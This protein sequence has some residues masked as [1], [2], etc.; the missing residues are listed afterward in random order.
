MNKLI[1]DNF[2]GFFEEN[3][4]L[5]KMR[6]SRETDI[7][8]AFI[9]NE[10]NSGKNL[11]FL[12]KKLVAFYD[13]RLPKE[14][15]TELLNLIEKNKNEIKNSEDILS[16]YKKYYNEFKKITGRNETS[17]TSKL[18][19][20]YNKNI[21]LYDSR[22]MKF[23]TDIGLPEEN[24]AIKKYES[25]FNTYKYFFGNDNIMALLNKL[26]NEIYYGKA[27]K[28]LDEN[29]IFDTLMYSIGD[30]DEFKKLK[31]IIK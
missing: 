5:I 2:I 13:I 17:F 28:Y 16:L 8:Y 26:K 7:E 9:I 25:L 4:Y 6:Y 12:Q 22:V 24:T 23:L 14:K 20:L 30:I 15:T 27:I 3:Y 10:I 31:V 1:V 29:K 11:S 19:N 21:K 18:L